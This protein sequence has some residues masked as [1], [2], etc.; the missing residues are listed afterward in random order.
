VESFLQ[1]VKRR[2]VQKGTLFHRV[3]PRFRLDTEGRR[4]TEEIRR[5]THPLAVKKEA[6]KWIEDHTIG[7]VAMARQ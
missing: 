7:S 3:Y 5:E 2:P 6:G 1:Y 4:L